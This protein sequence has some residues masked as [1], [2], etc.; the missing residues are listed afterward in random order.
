L[1]FSKKADCLGFN[2][3][4][5]VS[6]KQLVRHTIFELPARR[7]LL[8]TCFLKK[9]IINRLHEALPQIVARNGLPG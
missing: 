1:P 7:S 9:N 3:I 6:R 4:L 8:T 5:V 2:Q